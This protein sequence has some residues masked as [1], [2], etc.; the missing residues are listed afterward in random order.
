MNYL[1]NTYSIPKISIIMPTY[2]GGKFISKSIKSVL[3]QT[4]KD[5]ELI[6][7]N[8]ASNDKTKNIINKF[9]T[10]DKRIVYLENRVNR[11]TPFSRNRGLKVARGEYIAYCDHD[12]IYYPNHIKVLK[13]YLDKH[14]DIGLAYTDT[15][16]IKKG[17]KPRVRHS[18]DFDKYKLEYSNYIT[19]INVMHRKLCLEKSGLF[20]EN[21][22][23]KEHSCEDWDLW[24]RIS[25]YF[26]FA[27]IKKNTSNFILHG[28]NRSFKIDFEP[29]YLYIFEKRLKRIMISKSH[30][31]IGALIT[32]GFCNLTKKRFQNALKYFIKLKNLLFK[33][34]KSILR[35]EN[36]FRLNIYITICYF[37]SKN[38]KMALRLCNK[39]LKVCPGRLDIIEI[40]AKILIIQ[41]KYY[42][43]LR[44]INKGIL[45][46]KFHNLRGVIYFNMS[47]FK[48]A[49]KEFEKE[50]KKYPKLYTPRYNLFLA[51]LKLNK[52]LSYKGASKISY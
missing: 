43:A 11:G 2:N 18:V 17:F 24:L 3:K 10:K 13:D 15:L 48:L 20:D 26:K 37:Y 35:E 49:I 32:K 7:I 1:S 19:P 22:I 51:Y 39:I 31:H 36:I 52:Y 8:D 44:I 12:D 9:L 34:R 30:S 45:K 27:H 38:Y 14:A 16:W 50:I 33:A 42:L 5:F 46:D 41:Q 23:I 29:S 47:K 21:K 6:V 40:K 25:D 4:F 28:E